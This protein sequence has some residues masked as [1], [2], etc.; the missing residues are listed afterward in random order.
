MSPHLR[1]PDDNKSRALVAITT[2]DSSPA[3]AA[4]PTGR[5]P[6]GSLGTNS[7]TM[8]FGMRQR[9]QPQAFEANP[10]FNGGETIKGPPRKS[11]TMSMGG[12]GVGGAVAPKADVMKNGVR[13]E[14]AIA[15]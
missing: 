15:A 7:N 11:L 13:V 5:S 3:A 4:F 6:L 2:K 9:R 12:P 14:R 1:T 10:F 8:G